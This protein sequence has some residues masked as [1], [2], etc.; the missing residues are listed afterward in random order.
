MLSKIATGH[1]EV[2]HAAGTLTLD[3]PPKIGRHEP[4]ALGKGMSGTPVIGEAKTGPDLFELRALE[5]LY[6][7]THHEENGEWAALVLVVPKGFRADA[8]RALA[9]AGAAVERASV[10]EVTFPGSA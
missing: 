4:D 5:Q 2:T 1:C 9:E 8:E 6:D 3:D 7:F 10:I